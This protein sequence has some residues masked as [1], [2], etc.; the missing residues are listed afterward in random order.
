MARSP[1]RD[2]WERRMASMEY[3][4]RRA[5]LAAEDEEVYR[6]DRVHRCEECN[7]VLDSDEAGLT[8]C[9]Y[10]QSETAYAERHT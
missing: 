3:H 1:L 5:Q 6:F 4:K 8:L 7:E 10:C 2:A 9:P